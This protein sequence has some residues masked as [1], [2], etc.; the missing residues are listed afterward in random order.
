MDQ[1]TLRVAG[2]LMPLL[3]P[4]DW[5]V[6]KPMVQAL[7]Q[8]LGPDRVRAIYETLVGVRDQQ[9]PGLEPA[10]AWEDLTA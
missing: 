2:V 10:P 6:L 4:G 3:F 8:K 5:E 7:A 9:S 1:T